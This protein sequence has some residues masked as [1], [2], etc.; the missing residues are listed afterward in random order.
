MIRATRPVRV[1]PFTIW[2][3]R[4]GL[5][6]MAILILG[7]IGSTFMMWRIW[8]P[9]KIP[10]AAPTVVAD[11]P[12]SPFIS[13]DPV[14]LPAKHRDSPRKS[15][16]G[17]TFNEEDR[18]VD[19][20]LGLPFTFTT[21]RTWSCLAATVGLDAKAW[22]CIDLNAGSERPQLDLVCRHC[23]G[24]CT[25]AHRAEVNA[26]MKHQP[27]YPIANSSGTR[28]VEHTVDNRYMLTVDRVFASP[29][30]GPADWVVVIQATARPA[31]A[32]SVQKIV[33]DI[34]S[35]TL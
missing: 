2:V 28:F 17:P 31:D 4:I 3:A 6:L 5:G 16:A 23:P 21:P 19:M 26:Q 20:K 8:R 1:T 30:G 14:I 34:Y 9:E 11:L 24:A 10:A 22:R 25:E 7:L 13:P 32:A 29:P 12:G 27:P 18:T 33:N 15:L 35:Q